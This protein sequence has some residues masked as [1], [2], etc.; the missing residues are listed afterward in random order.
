M[1]VGGCWNREKM[2]LDDDLTRD[3]YFDVLPVVSMV[4]KLHRV[5]KKL[6]CKRLMSPLSETVHS[7]FLTQDSRTST[8]NLYA[9]PLYYTH[10]TRDQRLAFRFDNYITLIDLPISSVPAEKI[11]QRGVRLVLYFD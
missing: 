2:T 10:Q 4:P 8:E 6:R 5:S 1:L 3:N 9:C 11:A 7:F